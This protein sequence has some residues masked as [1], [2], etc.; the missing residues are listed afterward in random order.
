MNQLI[1][2]TLVF[3]L[4]TNFVLLA[5]SRLV[6]CI[7]AAAIQ[8][9]LLGLLALAVQVGKLSMVGILLPVTSMVVKGLLLPWL[10]VRAMRDAN[11]I[12]EIEPLIG[13]NL[14]VI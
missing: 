13:Y 14:S 12:R 4:L 6:T 2:A 5:S 9:M 1:S 8:G 3:L 10:L 11:T 7:R